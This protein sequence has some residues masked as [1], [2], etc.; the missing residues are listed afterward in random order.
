MDVD[1]AGANGTRWSDVYWTDSGA[2]L[3]Q[4]VSHG[5]TKIE[6]G[7]APKDGLLSA[8]AEAA[9]RL[10]QLSIV[11]CGLDSQ[12]LA[13]LGDLFHNSRLQ[14]I[15]VS[16]NPDVEAKDWAGFWSKLP[17]SVT[18]WDF[19]DDDLSDEALPSL[20][21]AAC[22]GNLQE[23]LIDGNSFTDITPLLQVVRQAPSLDELDVGDNDF[24]DQQVCRLIEHLPGSSLNTLVLGRNPIGDASCV[25]LVQV[26]PR[27]R[28]RGLHL[29]STGITDAT[30][31]ALSSVLSQTQ[32][33]EL[34]V[35]G[36]QV[37][38]AGVLQLASALAGS[39]LRDLDIEDI[40]LTPATLAVVE[41]TLPDCAMEDES[42]Q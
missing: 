2:G 11:A 22:R 28:L 42:T 7:L 37:K 39:K 6:V 8:I 33:E 21:Q 30:L 5:E 20:L 13:R 32:L 25:P 34:D 17:A 23:L 41:A 16:N 15:G 1:D 27:C 3:L 36:T 40:Q 35:S 4:A 26:L 38:D 12:D 29:D 9:G 31:L 24:N 18:K 14:A 10:E 19:G